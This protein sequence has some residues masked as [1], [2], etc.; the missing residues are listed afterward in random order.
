MESVRCDVVRWVADNPRPGWVEAHLT[1]AKGRRWLF[2]EKPPVFGTGLDRSSHFP[3]PAAI[4][5]EVVS[6]G[7]ELEAGLVEIRLLDG[8]Q[9]QDG[10]VRFLVR[11][12]QVDR[13]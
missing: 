11:A 13:G 1:D 6:D 5:C 10:T 12:D 2:F 9:A 8:V 4:P 3:V 7:G